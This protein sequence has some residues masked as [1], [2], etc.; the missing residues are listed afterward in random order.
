[1]TD[2]SMN[3]TGIEIKWFTGKKN[4]HQKPEVRKRKSYFKYDNSKCTLI[5]KK[6]IRGL[7]Y[8]NGHLELFSS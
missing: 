2:A 8:L 7:A 1:M 5:Y 4:T 3:Q 6:K